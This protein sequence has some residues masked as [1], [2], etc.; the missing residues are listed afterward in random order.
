MDD[1]TLRHEQIK[2]RTAEVEAVVAIMRKLAEGERLNDELK[3][4]NLDWARFRNIDASRPVMAG[5]SLGGSAAV[6]PR[7]FRMTM[8]LTSKLARSVFEGF[9]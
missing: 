6:S 1:T 2:C 5:H 4:P 9:N 7:S 3:L 8:V